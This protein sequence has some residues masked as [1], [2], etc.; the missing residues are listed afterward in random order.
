VQA[1]RARIAKDDFTAR[2]AVER[3]GPGCPDEQRPCWH[4]ARRLPPRGCKSPRSGPASTCL[5]RNHLHRSTTVRSLCG[6]RPS[7]AC[8]G[9]ARRFAAGRKA[10]SR[11]GVLQLARSAPKA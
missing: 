9:T 4:G 5:A 2:G 1:V 3:T 7:S 6:R 10:L 8:P 11:T